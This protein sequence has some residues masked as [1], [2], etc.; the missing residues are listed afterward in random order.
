MAQTACELLF[1]GI[2]IG[3]A[4]VKLKAKIALE[5]LSRISIVYRLHEQK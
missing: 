3:S 2:F 5:V 1:A 4:Y